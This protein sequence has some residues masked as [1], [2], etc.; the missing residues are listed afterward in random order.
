[1]EEAICNTHHDNSQRHT[2]DILEKKKKE[3]W[4][5]PFSVLRPSH[6]DALQEWLEEIP[7]LTNIFFPS[8][9]TI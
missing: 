1:M 3:S 5:Q 8:S 6:K 9:I 2:V 4:I 7:T